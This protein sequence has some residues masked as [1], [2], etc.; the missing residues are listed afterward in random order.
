MQKTGMYKSH[1][2]RELK[3]LLLKELMKCINP[4]DREFKF[5]RITPLGKKVLEYLNKIDN[6]NKKK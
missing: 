3:A 6:C 4:N 1:T 2:S 5:Y